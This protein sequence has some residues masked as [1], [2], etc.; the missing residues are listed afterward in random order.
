MY[1]RVINATCTRPPNTTHIQQLMVLYEDIFYK[2]YCD[3]Y[4]A[5]LY[6]NVNR[7]SFSY[8][9]VHTQIHTVVIRTRDLRKN[10]FQT[11]S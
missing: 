3:I 1:L 5:K 6:Q 7:T 11:H 4:T 8:F 10:N 9:T 2:I